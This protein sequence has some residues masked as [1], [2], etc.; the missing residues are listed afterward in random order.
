MW[1]KV[2]DGG[3]GDTGYDIEVDSERNVYVAGRSGGYGLTLTKYD[4]NGNTLWF[5][6]RP[7]N[8]IGNVPILKLDR[9]SI[10]GIFGLQHN[11]AVSYMLLKN[12]I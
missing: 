12:M 10:Y 4:E 9:K 7:D 1:Q 2:F 5:R 6:N 3:L 11:K 8:G